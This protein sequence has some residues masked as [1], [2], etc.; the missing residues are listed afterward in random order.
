[1][2]TP[3]WTSS[4]T[5]SGQIRPG[6]AILL[7]APSFPPPAQK[8]SLLLLHPFLVLCQSAAESLREDAGSGDDHPVPMAG[9][10]RQEVHRPPPVSLDRSL[11]P[12]SSAPLPCHSFA[13]PIS[14]AC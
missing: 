1:M 3:T 2:A 12:P 4:P 9:I 10:Q 5:C 8:A 11:P 13:S 7:S 14:T 6:T